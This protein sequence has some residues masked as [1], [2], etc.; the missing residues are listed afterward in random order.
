MGDSVADT[1]PDILESLLR[2]S[3][4][5]TSD[6]W[7]EGLGPAK[8]KVPVGWA[9]AIFRTYPP[10]L[11]TSSTGGGTGPQSK[12]AMRLALSVTFESALP[13]GG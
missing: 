13:A 5:L 1:V 11:S 9:A 8:E 7:H 10:S 2:R 12:P 3:P 6:Q 4:G